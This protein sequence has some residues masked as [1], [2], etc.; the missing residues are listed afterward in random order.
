MLISC[1]WPHASRIWKDVLQLPENPIFFRGALGTQKAKNQSRKI[2]DVD[3]FFRKWSANH[4]CT[5]FQVA[6]CF[7]ESHEY[8]LQVVDCNFDHPCAGACYEHGCAGLSFQGLD[9]EAACKK[10]E[11]QCATIFCEPLLSQCYHSIMQIPQ[12]HPIE[13]VNYFVSKMIQ[14]VNY[15]LCLLGMCVSI[16]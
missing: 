2:V 4:L 6:C 9:I 11:L 3:V 15:F 5:N 8:K 16:A 13:T 7:P 10:G 14:A 12:Y 1:V